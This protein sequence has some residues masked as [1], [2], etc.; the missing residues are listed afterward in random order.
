MDAGVTIYSP[1][2][3]ANNIQ[4]SVAIRDGKFTLAVSGG[5][6]MGIGGV[7]FGFAITIDVDE[8]KYQG[9]AIGGCI[10]SLFQDCTPGWELR[11]RDQLREAL[12]IANPI[13]RAKYLNDNMEWL[14]LDPDDLPGDLRQAYNEHLDLMRTFQR[15]QD[16]VTALAAQEAER[17]QRFL[18][19]LRENPAEAMAEASWFMRQLEL[20]G[21]YWLDLG[22]REEI[23]RDL[24]ALNLSLK[25]NASGTVSFEWKER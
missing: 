24:K 6:A 4:A 14:G 18:T 5:L 12:A 25:V 23:D 22:L 17:Y 15:L 9:Q 13:E 1:G 7:S 21:G 11:A 3:F 20:Y 19:L 16:N 8:W 2:L 10:A